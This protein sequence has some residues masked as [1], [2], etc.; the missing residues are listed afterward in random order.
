[1]EEGGRNIMCGERKVEL[2]E[3]NG[4]MTLAKIYC[5]KGPK[6]YITARNAKWKWNLEAPGPAGPAR[7]NGCR[8]GEL[9][10]YK[11]GEI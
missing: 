11:P 3:G 7:R 9:S 1:M 5:L 4:T 8:R 2:A 10:I 6:R